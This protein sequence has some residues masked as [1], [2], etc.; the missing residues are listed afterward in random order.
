M[1]D[2][3]NYTVTIAEGDTETIECGTT[4]NA[5][6]E[7]SPSGVA[8]IAVSP[9]GNPPDYIMCDTTGFDSYDWSNHQVTAGD[10][11]IVNKPQSETVYNPTLEAKA[12]GGSITLSVV[13][14]KG[15]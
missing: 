7:T 10:N 3:W 6:N 1:A 11:D 9:S 12:Y 13:V 15:A 14:Q 5:S 2:E 4:K 8:G